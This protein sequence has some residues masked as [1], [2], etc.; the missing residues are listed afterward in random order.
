M[1][2]SSWLRNCKGS[3]ER[4]AALNQIRRRKPRDP[5][6]D[7]RPQ[8]EALEDR[9]L[10]SPYLV[11]TTADSGPGSLRDAITQINADTNH[12]LYASPSNSSV[13]E[14]DFNVTAASD[15][16]GGGSGYN[17]TTGVA[18]ITPQTSLPSITNAVLIDGYTQAGGSGN[19]NPFG[20]ADNAVL[21]VELNGSAVA[22]AYGLV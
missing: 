11:T 8:L 17:S 18:T 19:T 22:N 13:D 5:R 2:F 6:V 14:I 1:L 3:L 12:T 10:L 20:Q 21:K 15:V 4:R 7:P 16:A 9:T